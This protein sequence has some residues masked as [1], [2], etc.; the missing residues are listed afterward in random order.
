MYLPH[1]NTQKKARKQEQVT[2]QEAQ[3]ARTNYEQLLIEQAE[4]N[5][6]NYPSNI[7]TLQASLRTDILTESGGFGENTWGEYKLQ[8]ADALTGNA[9]TCAYK[10]MLS[11]LKEKPRFSDVTKTSYP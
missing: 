7:T 1:L 4:R 9:R 5:T 8:K 3:E 10:S 6:R 11:M 2:E